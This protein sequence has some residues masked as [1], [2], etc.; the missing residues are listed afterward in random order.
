MN[1]DVSKSG[2]S[3]IL[4]MVSLNNF[5][6]S[7]ISIFV[8]IYLLQL[9]YSFKMVLAWLAITHSSLLLFAFCA[10]YFSNKVGL[11]HSLHV[12]FILLISHL[13]LLLKLP[14][15][16]SL[17]WITPIVIGMEMAFYWMPLNI[18]FVRNTDK[19]KMGGAM[20]KLFV[21]PRIISMFSPLIGAII[22][23]YFG[24]NA[25]FVIAMALVVLAVIPVLPLHSEKTHFEF[26]IKRIKEIFKE[27]KDFFLPEVIDNL[28]ED[29]GVI[30]SIFI[31]LKLASLLQI[32][33]VG[34]I[35]AVTAILFTLTIGNLTDKW[36]KHFLIKIGATLITLMWVI[37]FAIGQYVPNKWLFYIATIGMTLSLKTFSIPYGSLMFNRARKDDA[38]FIVLR[39]VP[40][41]LGRLILF[42][43]TA[44]LSESLPIL[45]L[46]VGILFIYFVFLNTKKL[47]SKTA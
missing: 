30:W 32:G 29:A 1:K 12:R 15:N 20:S 36:N 28:A 9:E 16:P 43:L 10:V 13:L 46:L 5:A 6:L 22:T 4:Q 25:L 39:E 2:L 42:A 7:L 34:T 31:Y 23:S 35:S 17:F 8:P 21:Y 41:I 24:F 27:N 47:E 26:S 33:I 44:L 38:Q 14:E 18:L 3:K 37:N 40:T 45:F 19:E 11:V